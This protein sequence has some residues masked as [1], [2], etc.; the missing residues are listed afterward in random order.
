MAVLERPRTG[1]RYV[2][3]WAQPAARP[4]AQDAHTRGV[5]TILRPAVGR[6]PPHRRAFPAA[7]HVWPAPRPTPTPSSRAPDWRGAVRR[8][9]SRRTAL[10]I[11]VGAVLLIAFWAYASVWRGEV[12]LTTL[13]T[14]LAGAGGVCIGMSLSLGTAGYY[15]RSVAPA[16]VYRRTFGL[17]GFVLASLHALS[18]TVLH[19][20]RYLWGLTSHFWSAD[21]V[22]GLAAI[23]ILGVM[24]AVSNERA[25]RLIGARRWKST[26]RLGYGAY[27]LLVA[28]AVCIEGADWWQWIRLLDTVPPPRLLVSM[29]AIV[30][31]ALRFAMELSIRQQRQARSRQR[32]A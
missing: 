4:A 7:V 8:A 15:V 16:I 23:S 13:A 31:L 12:S 19:P 32:A 1:S 28:R 5:G 10:P 11:A 6:R 14:A 21:I 25:V 22:L 29:L 9:G 18:L 17:L 26:L 24:A 30:V 2:G 20:E 27:A 3:T